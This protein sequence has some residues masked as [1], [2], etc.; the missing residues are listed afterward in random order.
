MDIKFY[1]L[2]KTIGTTSKQIKRMITKQALLLS[3]IGIPFGLIIGFVIG[4]ACLPLI[5]GISDN[6]G[7]KAVVSLNPIIFIGA[8]LFALITVFISTRKPGR[9]AA[10]F[11]C[12]GCTLQRCCR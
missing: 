12:R 11:S 6:G 7:V 1:G 5:V 9:M 4:K 10:C 8:A 3:V 2:L